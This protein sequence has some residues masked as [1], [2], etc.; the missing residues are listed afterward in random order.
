MC[1]QNRASFIA[2]GPLIQNKL[3]DPYIRQF[4]PKSFVK[5]ILTDITRQCMISEIE[6]LSVCAAFLEQKVID[7]TLL[8]HKAV[9]LLKSLE[10]DHSNLEDPVRCLFI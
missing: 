6:S 10:L 2:L 7:V 1:N 8:N 3:N 5:E 9:T 4:T